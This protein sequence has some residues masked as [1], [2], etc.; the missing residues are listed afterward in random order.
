M[1]IE[2]L[3]A[4]LPIENGGFVSSNFPGDPEPNGEPTLDDALKQAGQTVRF[5]EDARRE[6]TLHHLWFRSPSGSG[7][8]PF[9]LAGR[10]PAAG[11]VDGGVSEI[12]HGP[13]TTEA[14]VLMTKKLSPAN[15]GHAIGGRQYDSTDY[16]W[17]EMSTG[18]Y[19]WALKN[20]QD[21]VNAAIAQITSGAANPQDAAALAQLYLN[22]VGLG[23][24]VHVNN[25][26]PNTSSGGTGGPPPGGEDAPI[27]V[28]ATNFIPPHTNMPTLWMHYD[29]LAFVDA[30]LVFDDLDRAVIETRVDPDVLINANGQQ[31]LARLEL[32]KGKVTDYFNQLPGNGVFMTP[33][34]P[35]TVAELRDRWA[36]TDFHITNENYQTDVFSRGGRTLFNNGN[37]VF[38]T[39][40]TNLI[41][42]MAN[43]MRALWYI[44]H[45]LTHATTL[46]DNNNFLLFSNG[47]PSA[48]DFSANERFANDFARFVAGTMGHPFN[49]LFHASD[50]GFSDNPGMSFIPN[51]SDPGGGDGGGGD[52]GG[53]G[54]EV[55]EY[56]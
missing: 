22:S 47:T 11:A 18:D 29:D 34:G 23:E 44:L 46:G 36:K 8:T 40:I 55:N 50:D 2:G 6:A 10:H 21:D 56:L 38:E 3:D 20:F 39:N 30:Q 17:Q 27:L 4:A 31:A 37:P 7:D 13:I 5:A 48:A 52:G 43:E 24:I 41:G 45:E 53:G 12:E 33:K 1:A 9:H 49:P 15:I 16:Y 19:D 35:I 32:I 51:P 42:Y 25:P 28:T 54:G 14:D 26:P